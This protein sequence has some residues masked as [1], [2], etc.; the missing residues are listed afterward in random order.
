MNTSTQTRFQVVVRKTL[1]D[2]K[3]AGRKPDSIRG[4]A[5]KMA[6]GD[7]IRFETFKRS[8]LKWLAPGEPHPTRESRAVVA[9]ALGLERGDLDDEESRPVSIDDLLRLRVRELYLEQVASHE[10]TE[11]T[12]SLAKATVGSNHHGG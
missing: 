11:P 9:D 12:A 5:R 7:P 2:N 4:L 8:L 1:A 3:V 10:K 6:N